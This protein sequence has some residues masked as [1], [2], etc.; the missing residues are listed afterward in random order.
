MKIFNLLERKEE[1][2]A[3]GVPG[4]S[5]INSKLNEGKIEKR[6]KRKEDSRN[7]KSK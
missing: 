2:K 4:G 1:Q 5:K 3:S 7:R 6:T